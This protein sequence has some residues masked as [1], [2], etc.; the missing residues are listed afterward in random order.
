[1]SD[2]FR[3]FPLFRNRHVMTI[4]PVLLPHKVPAVP[5]ERRLFKVAPDSQIAC[6]H[7]FAPDNKQRKTVIL[8]HG[9]EG[10]ADSSY[11]LSTAHKLWDSGFNVLRLNLRNCGNTMSLTPTLYNAGLSSDIIAVANEL[12]TVDGVTSLFAAGFSLGG[13]I[14]LKAAAELGESPDQLLSGVCAI[15]PSLDLPA[16]VV[17]LEK[18]FNRFYEIRFVESLKG[19]VRAKHALY[20]HLYDISKLSSLKRIR[21]FDD[22]YTS[23]DAGYSCAEEYYVKASAL[24]MM[25][26]V[27]VPVLIITSQDDPIVPYHSFSAEILQSPFI[28]VLAPEHGGH[29]GFFGQVA[30]GGGGLTDRFWAEEQIVRFCAGIASGAEQ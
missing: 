2:Q 18:G 28:R 21:A 12:R 27:K 29:A 11:I 10:S 22:C 25:A 13:N 4:L 5:G 1:M 30:G 24:P 8:V 20:P 19:K 14:V 16:C 9:L 6:Y 26:R 7:H 15:S 23:Q 3:P 17:A